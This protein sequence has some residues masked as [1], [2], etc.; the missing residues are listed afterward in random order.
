MRA[1]KRLTLIWC[2]AILVTAGLAGPPPA[3]AASPGAS[4]IPVLAYYY[5]WYDPSSWDRAKSDY[6]MLGRYSSDDIEVMRQHIR[7]A[8]DAGISGFIVSW[9]STTTLNRRLEQLIQVADSESF[10]LA[11]IYQGLDFNRQPLDATRIAADLNQFIENY[12]ADP[13]FDI[14]GGPLVVWSGTWEYSVADVKS[15]VDST[16]RDACGSS[17]DFARPCVT[18][19]ASERSPEGVRRLA[20]IVDGDAYYWSSVNPDTYPEYPAKLTEMRDAVK[21]TGG[22][23]IAPAAPGFDAR[24]IGGTTVVDRKDGD[25]LRR[26]L[27]AAYGS[28]PDAVGVIS[29]NEFSENSEVEPSLN[30]GTTALGVLADVMN[31]RPPEVPDLDSSQPTSVVSTPGN[32]MVGRILALGL[33]VGLLIGSGVV[34]SRRTNRP[35]RLGVRR[36]IPPNATDRRGRE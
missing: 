1:V 6:P 5:I 8:K 26:E 31:G 27:D 34:I 16:K 10:K 15:V 9:K 24:L 20:G 19:L 30:Y 4:P 11:I 35:I 14:L 25:T 2:A 17:G 21:E 23:W 12:A 13:A 32:D 33:I 28:S 3:A 18:L 7:W 36:L 29:W 22:I